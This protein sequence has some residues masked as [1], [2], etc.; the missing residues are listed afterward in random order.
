MLLVN[1]IF[2][3]HEAKP[4]GLV[5]RRQSLEL[6]VSI[7]SEIVG[8]SSKVFVFCRDMLVIP[9]SNLASPV[10]G[11]SPS[12]FYWVQTS[13]LI[14][15]PVL[16]TLVYLGGGPVSSFFSTSDLPDDS[17]RPSLFVL[18]SAVPDVAGVGTFER[19]CF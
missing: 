19:V 8:L 1:P 12:W 18:I 15:Y 5:F 3:I 11:L 6:E 10:P 14:A 13:I 17:F 2:Y 16:I 7:P 4:S 9:E